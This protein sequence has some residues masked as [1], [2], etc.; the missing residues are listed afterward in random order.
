[1]KHCS[2]CF[3][4]RH[5][6]DDCSQAQYHIYELHKAV[7][8]LLLLIKRRKIEWVAPG[9]PHLEDWLCPFIEQQY[10]YAMIKQ[11]YH[12]IR[13]SVPDHMHI[14]RNANRSP[15]EM[16]TPQRYTAVL[17][18]YWRTK[19]TQPDDWIT[20]VPTE[21]EVPIP[22]E[23]LFRILDP[24]LTFQDGIL[25]YG[26]PL[27]SAPP[28]QGEIHPPDSAPIGGLWHTHTVREPERHT[29]RER[30]PLITLSV[31]EWVRAAQQPSAPPLPKV[32]LSYTPALTYN[33]PTCS[34]CLTAEPYYQTQCGHDFCSCLFQ[35][36]IEYGNQSC[37][38][39]RT[40]LT[41]VRTTSE[42]CY[43]SL[44]M[45]GSQ[46]FMFE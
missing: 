6:I 26:T 12:R 33:E 45:V 23:G 24:E 35:H 17:Q 3:S 8:L 36:M 10:S 34:I 32:Q 29:V 13:R 7:H 31:P 4:D 11:M 44:R 21:T 16:R 38:M 22:M 43:Q 2:Y 18:Y 28:L 19:R 37:P 14:H 41:S 5:D 30:P 42:P 39:C 25:R 27:P 40:D 1:M 46:H 9:Y 15:F 20:P